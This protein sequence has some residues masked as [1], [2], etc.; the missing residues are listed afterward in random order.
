MNKIIFYSR[1]FVFVVLMSVGITES[2]PSA[3]RFV[4]N[5]SQVSTVASQT[6]SNSSS[7]VSQCTPIFS[8]FASH[9]GYAFAVVIVAAGGFGI[10]KGYDW[11]AKGWIDSIRTTLKD[12]KERLGIVY[13]VLLGTSA[14]IK[15]LQEMQQTIKND[16]ILIIDD[17]KKKNQKL[18]EDLKIAQKNVQELNSTI[19]KVGS[20]VEN[21]QKTLDM[22]QISIGDFKGNNEDQNK[23]IEV[24]MRSLKQMINSVVE[25]LTSMSQN[26]KTLQENTY[27][28]ESSLNFLDEQ[29][30]QVDSQT[31]QL[32]DGLGQLGEQQKQQSQNVEKRVTDVKN[33]FD[34]YIQRVSETIIGC[35]KQLENAQKTVLDKVTSNQK[36]HY[37]TIG[38]LSKEVAEI[39]DFTSTNSEKLQ[40]YFV[41][42]KNNATDFQKYIDQVNHLQVEITTLKDKHCRQSEM[43][44]DEV[45]KLSEKVSAVGEELKIKIT[46]TFKQMR[47]RVDERNQ[48]QEKLIQQLTSDKD[49]YQR[50]YEKMLNKNQINQLGG[51]QLLNNLSGQVKNRIE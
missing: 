7:F 42:Q 37:D 32:S 39:S 50:K 40:Q 13:E 21:L 6:L 11:W 27:F 25:D 46:E 19:E 28:F 18:Q 47:V 26:A 51:D 30:K 3:P 5:P 48:Q 31:K 1:Y 33:N 36:E 14:E 17:N 45:D 16:Q 15:K 2:V 38:K 29:V 12:L 35:Q 23:E 43:M 49:R 8:L 4:F 20:N 41:E 44:N 9:Q 24:K 22:L 34:N 10:Y